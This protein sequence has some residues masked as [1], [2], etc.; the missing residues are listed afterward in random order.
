MLLIVNLS[1]SSSFLS[2]IT[3]YN[4]FSDCILSTIRRLHLLNTKYQSIAFTL[5]F[6]VEIISFTLLFLLI[7]VSLM[8]L[9]FTNNVIWCNSINKC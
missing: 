6:T 8:H 3:V 7:S 9:Q 2:Q 5:Y 4:Y 1:S